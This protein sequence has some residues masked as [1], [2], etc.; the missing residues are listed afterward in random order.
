MRGA[1]VEG[2]SPPGLLAWMV[3]DLGSPLALASNFLGTPEKC[4]FSFMFLLSKAR[5]LQE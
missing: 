4:P 3:G 2:C 5:S 1:S